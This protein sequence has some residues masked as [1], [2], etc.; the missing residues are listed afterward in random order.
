MSIAIPGGDEL[1][2]ARRQIRRW[3]DTELSSD[4]ADEV[5]LA[6][7]EALANA[8]E[9]GRPPITVEMHWQR[10]RGQSTLHVAVCDTGSWRVT[11]EPT[12]RGLGIP[13]MSA[14][15]DTVSIETVD[16]TQVRLVRQY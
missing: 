4:D 11:A 5:L 13:I 9:H 10:A 16:G 14:V 8:L 12:S 2:A 7:G 1:A 15:M 3:L 6:C